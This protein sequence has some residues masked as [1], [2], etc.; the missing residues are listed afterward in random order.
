MVTLAVAEMPLAEL[1]SSLPGL[2][3]RSWVPIFSVHEVTSQGIIYLVRHY[4]HQAVQIREADDNIQNH[5]RRGLIT[6][7]NAKANIS[8][9]LDYQGNASGGSQLRLCLSTTKNRND[10]SE[11]PRLVDPIQYV[12]AITSCV[13]NTRSCA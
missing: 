11:M 4:H 10:C 8:I 6:S 9:R 13:P 7:Q 5:V 3:R 2:H 12:L 1:T